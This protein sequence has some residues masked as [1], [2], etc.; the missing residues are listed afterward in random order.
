M[1][2]PGPL[3]VREGSRF[4][5]YD[6]RRQHTPPIPVPAPVLDEGAEGRYYRVP[7]TRCEH[8]HFSRPGGPGRGCRRCRPSR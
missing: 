3:Y 6:E 7:V 4:V 8:G 1:T 2:A 5:V